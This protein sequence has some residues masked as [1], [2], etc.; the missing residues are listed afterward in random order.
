MIWVKRSAIALLAL[1]MVLVIAVAALLYTPAG[2]KVAVWGAQKVLPSLSVGGS[3]GSLLNGFALEQ[4]RYRDDNIDLGVAKLALDIE[5]SC[6]L[7]PAVCISNLAVSGVRFSMPQLPPVQE[8]AE[9]E[10][11]SEPLTEISLP[12]PITLSRLVLDDI[13]LDVL[14]NQVSWQHFSSAAEMVGDKLVLKP[15]D[16]NKI[17]LTLAPAAEGDAQEVEES[18][19]GK[20]E[21][22]VLPEVLIPLSVEIQ[23]FTVEDFTLHGETPQ[24][25]KKLELVA[26]ADRKSV[27]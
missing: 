3:Q 13:E 20:P 19:T 17:D 21:A 18:N 11:P 27:V 6:L 16:W 4:L 25:V 26:V 7:T 8:D 2:I 9:E 22:I 12:I 10:S 15:T 23:R 24:T 1:L 14:G 5:D